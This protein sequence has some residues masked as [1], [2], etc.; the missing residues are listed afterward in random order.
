M[1][2]Q[3]CIAVPICLLLVGSS[4]RLAQH[5]QDSVGRFD[6]HAEDVAAIQRL[7]ED[8]HDGWLAGDADALVALYADGAVLMPQSQPAVLGK[9]AIHSLYQS[10]FREYTVKGDGETLEIEI[11]GNWA[12]L[13]GTYTLTATPKAGGERLEDAGKHLFILKRQPD[14]SWKIARLIANSDQPPP[15]H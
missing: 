9:E 11:G 12:F 10:V 2:T 7:T 13:R 6:E 8:W 4:C 15:G 1:E 14:G 5:R 3:L